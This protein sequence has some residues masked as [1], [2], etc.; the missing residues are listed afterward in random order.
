MA[1]PDRGEGNNP[2]PLWLAFHQSPKFINAYFPH[3]VIWG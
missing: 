1:C 2:V 3:C